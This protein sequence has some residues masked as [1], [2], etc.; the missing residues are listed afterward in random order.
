[1]DWSKYFSREFLVALVL[2]VVSIVALFK[3]LVDFLPWA[4]ACGGFVALFSAAKTV[5]KLK[6]VDK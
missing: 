2:I 6:G 4:G 3:G 1:M 5:Q